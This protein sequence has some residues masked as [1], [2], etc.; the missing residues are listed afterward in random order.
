[1]DRWLID[2]WLIVAL[3]LV[4]VQFFLIFRNQFSMLPSN[5]LPTPVKAATYRDHLMCWCVM[6]VLPNSE[7]QEIT[8]F[9]RHSDA[10]ARVRLL[11]RS[12]PNCHYTMVFDSPAPEAPAAATAVG[13]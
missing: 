13:G 6:R 5:E 2:R 10:E 12:H 1:M 11:Q 9:R 3:A 4:F 8:R 7:M